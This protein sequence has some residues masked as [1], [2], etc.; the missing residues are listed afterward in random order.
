MEQTEEGY[1]AR[2]FPTMCWSEIVPQDLESLLALLLSP[3]TKYCP[4]ATTVGHQLE[5]P[6][7]EGSK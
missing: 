2:Y 6:I 5:L 3:R 4:S 1:L 7:K